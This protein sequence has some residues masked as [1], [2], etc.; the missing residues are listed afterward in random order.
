[1]TEKTAGSACT[2]TIKVIL[3]YDKK[4]FFEIQSVDLQIKK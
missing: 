3:L 2:C 4:L 1:M